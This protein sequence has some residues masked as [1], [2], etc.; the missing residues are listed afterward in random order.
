M[1]NNRTL[2]TIV[3]T[4]NTL[5]AAT[6][7]QW[8]FKVKLE[9]GPTLYK[10]VTGEVEQPAPTEKRETIHKWEEANRNAMRI[11]IPSIVDPE[12]QLVR[13]CETAR[14]IWMVL[15]VNF[16]D[17]SMLRQCNVFKQLY[18]LK[19]APDKSIHDHITAFNKLYQE[20]K[21]YDQFKDLEDAI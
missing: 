17:V 18:S 20:I 5:T 3:S 10:I 19:L 9:L 11:L 6:Y 7:E 12:F 2:N 15:E 1:S 14:E 16:R 8:C 21:T 13:N 4:V